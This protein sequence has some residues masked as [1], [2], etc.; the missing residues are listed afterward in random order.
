MDTTHYK[1]SVLWNSDKHCVQNDMDKD[2]GKISHMGE[3]E[4]GLND[5]CISVNKTGQVSAGIRA[6]QDSVDG[7]PLNPSTRDSGPL[8][9]I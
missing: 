7:K 2:I 5:L 6:K 8:L 3:T 9:Q 4:S 1:A